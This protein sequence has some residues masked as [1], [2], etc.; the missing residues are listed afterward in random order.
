MAQ[1][2]FINTFYEAFLQAFYRA[3]PQLLQAGYDEQLRALMAEDF[4]DSNFYSCG[5]G[6]AGWSASDLV[7][8][9]AP[10]QRA[11][12]RAV[13][14]RGQSRRVRALERE[15]R[16]QAGEGLPA[17]RRVAANGAAL[18]P[19]LGRS[20]ARAEVAGYASTDRRRTAGDPCG[21]RQPSLPQSQP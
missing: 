13:G 1:I 12:A 7:V 20:P 5:L 8:N 2:I 3:Q 4:G 16:R 17:D 19:R 18:A 9:C 21:S 10:L 15:N 14:T 6:K 11:W